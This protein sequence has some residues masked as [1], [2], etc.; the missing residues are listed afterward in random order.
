MWNFKGYLWNST[1][2]ILP[3][4]WKINLLWNIEI[5]RA[6]RVKSSYAF[7]KRPP[8]IMN[9]LRCHCDW[10]A[11]HTDMESPYTICGYR[12]HYTSSAINSSPPSD[13]HM[14]QWIRS[15]LVQIIACRLFGAK[16]LSKP[17]LIYC[18]W[19]LRN[20]IQWNSK[21]NIKLF[22][23]EQNASKNIVCE[24]SAIFPRGD[25]LI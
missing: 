19:T 25:E 24:I 8:G 14:R 11:P 5:L 21:Q 23:H 7:L 10:R 17:M 20:K 9:W 12:R 18:Q 16:P 2:N 3:I 1:Q 4:H 22:I 6:L 15:A 13:A